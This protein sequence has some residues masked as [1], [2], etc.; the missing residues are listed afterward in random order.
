[1]PTIKVSTG[2]DVLVSEIDYPFI[3][4]LYIL[5][6]DTHGYVQCRFKQNSRGMGLETGSLHRIIMQPDK[7]RHI[8]VDHINGNKLDN[9]RENLRIISAQNNMRNSRKRNYEHMTSQYKGVSW[10]KGLGAWK[11]YVRPDVGKNFYGGAFSDEVAAANCYNYHVAELHGEYASFN[12]CPFMEKD[13]WEKFRKSNKI[14][15]KYRGVTKDKSNGKWIVQLWD[16]VNKKHIRSSGHLTEIDAAREYN[17]LAYKLKGD[18]AR[19]NKF[20]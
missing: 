14:H 5:S 9:R 3:D 17:R 7:G 18:K 11:V 13:E 2:E 19:L 6:I 4:L 12:D 10:H 1:M 20:P 16:G 15:S 8:H